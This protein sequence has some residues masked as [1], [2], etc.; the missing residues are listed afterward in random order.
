MT[1]SGGVL[2][3]GDWRDS[4]QAWH[5]AGSVTRYPHAVETGVKRKMRGRVCRAH[6]SGLVTRQ[7]GA[8]AE[9][10]KI[11]SV[12][13][14][15]KNKK[16]KK[17]GTSWNASFLLAVT[18]K[19]KSNIYFF[20]NKTDFSA[21]GTSNLRD[22]KTE[23]GDCAVAKPQSLKKQANMEVVTTLTTWGQLPNRVNL[24]AEIKMFLAWYKNWSLCMFT[25]HMVF[26]FYFN[27][28]HPF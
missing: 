6:V 9:S 1:L 14:M 3:L 21:T 8:A 28:A 12:C 27:I 26:F 18:C 10:Y 22:Y 4:P 16:K 17:K 11:R 13:V 5:I 15:R 19:K 25:F 23:N 24:K 20:T 7:W 2:G